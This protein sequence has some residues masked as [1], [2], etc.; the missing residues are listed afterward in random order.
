[1]YCAAIVFLVYSVD[2][3]CSVCRSVENLIESATVLDHEHSPRSVGKPI[4]AIALL[5]GIAVAPA[6]T[7]SPGRDQ[8][9]VTHDGNSA[10]V[11][12]VKPS[13]ATG[14]VCITI[15]ELSLLVSLFAKCAF[16]DDGTGVGATRGAGMTVT[17]SVLSSAHSLESST[18]LFPRGNVNVVSDSTPILLTVEDDGGLYH[19]NNDSDLLDD[20]SE[21]SLFLDDHDPLQY[22]RN[23]SGVSGSVRSA[24]HRRASS[25]VSGESKSSSAAGDY[26]SY[27]NEEDADSVLVSELAS[28]EWAVSAARELL[29][30]SLGL[31]QQQTENPAM[32]TSSINTKDSALNAMV[33]STVDNI[34]RIRGV[35]R[36]KAVALS[37]SLVDF[38]QLQVTLQLL[39][40]QQLQVSILLNKLK[41]EISQQQQAHAASASSA[42]AENDAFL[43]NLTRAFA[44]SNQ[45]TSQ[46]LAKRLI[47]CAP[48]EV[49]SQHPGSIQGTV[50]GQHRSGLREV[51]KEF[52]DRLQGSNGMH[53]ERDVGA[54][55]M[56]SGRYEGVRQALNKQ[57][58][59][60]NPNQ[61]LNASN[62]AKY[63]HGHESSG[64]IGGENSG[65]MDNT[66]NQ[67][68]LWIMLQN[69]FTHPSQTPDGGDG[70]HGTQHIL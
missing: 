8:P 61:P 45:L 15:K 39:E 62:Y 6:A 55:A 33:G 25:M 64:H 60:H 16:V 35:L 67:N 52:S 57:L 21:H 34:N 22:A 40:A 56:M 5:A 27:V 43:A 14:A 4:T 44:S 3:N 28:L 63:G 9:T 2:S 12:S 11:A 31:I 29:K 54:G 20:D 13:T 65:A 46:L 7:S 69:V 41:S 42:A 17:A 36:S 49:H 51:T 68:P 26:R 50:P 1:M 48:A 70:V 10:H 66:P 19:S 18:V 47:S 23:H 24:A 58:Q 32:A 30:Q 38:D 53:V 59:A 37:Q